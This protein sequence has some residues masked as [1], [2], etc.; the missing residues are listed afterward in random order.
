MHRLLLWLALADIKNL[1][2]IGDG[3]DH[4]DLGPASTTQDAPV[5]T[6][7]HPHCRR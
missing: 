6:T 2:N 4:K 1:G 7:R 5:W 3:G